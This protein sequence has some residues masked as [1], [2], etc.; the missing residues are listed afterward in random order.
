MTF[1]GTSG[2]GRSDPGTWSLGVS[3]ALLIVALWLPP[4]DRPQP[5]HRY[6][7]TFDISQSMDVTDVSLEGA[8]VSRLALARAAAA[9]L[10]LALPCGS[11]VGWNALAGQRT[12][13][14]LEPLEVCEHYAGLLSSLE[15]IDGRMRFA[16]ASSIGKGLHQSLRA[17]AAIGGS[18][19]LVLISDGHEAPPLSQGE[20]GMPRD[21]GLGVSGLIA[22]V[23]GDTLTRIPKSDAQGRQIGYW[24]ASE[25]KQLDGPEAG[26]SHEE[27]SSL[28]ERHLDELAQLASLGYRRLQIP[29]DLARHLLDEPG[30]QR[31][32]VPTDLRWVPV[33]LA[34]LLL[35]V[36]FLPRRSL[37]L[38]RSLTTRPKIQGPSS[39]SP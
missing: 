24:Q 3:L 17:A 1:M 39:V 12:M 13:L 38:R 33:S 36:R 28:R 25:V 6:L 18:T 35:A 37:L 5:I 11:R 9:E 27:L 8:S 32:T 34:L 4:I 15:G 21:E 31:H 10:L 2:I 30:T 19:R 26:Q 22:G 29:A 7:V 23:G 14:L 20:S 16:N